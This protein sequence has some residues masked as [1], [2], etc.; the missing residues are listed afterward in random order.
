[1]IE[2]ILLFQAHCSKEVVPFFAL[3]ILVLVLVATAIPTKADDNKKRVKDKQLSGED[4]I[5]NGE[6]NAD[7]DHEAFLGKEERQTF[8]QLSPE[9]SRERLGLII[10]KIDKNKDGFVSEDELK[11]WIQYVQ[12]RYISTDTDRMWKDYDTTEDNKI[13]WDAYMKRT[14][15]YS[16]GRCHDEVL[17][18]KDMISRDKR[19]WERA[20]TDK[21]NQLNKE[22]FSNF[23]H[24]EDAEH[25]REIVVLETLEDIDKDK[26]GFINEDE[27]IGDM[28]PDH[29]IGDPEPDW[30]ASE[31]KQFHDFRD[32]NKD[33]KMDPKEVMDWIIPA[34]YDH[35]A[36]ESK[37]LIYESD[38]DK[39]NRLTKQEILDKHDMFVGS[40]ATDFGEAL[41]R[42]DE[43]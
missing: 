30:V 39:D 21:D 25:M 16:E 14:Y 15:G 5:E 24:P 6:H 31:R 19:R 26:D 41:T 13:T 28:L 40:Q 3:L 1:M 9:E 35:S 33:G 42:H 27:Y 12:K 7:Y 38:V 36:A 20:D 18:Y 23:L 34:D 29:K 37:H 4:H 32:K 2:F 11:D 22:E 8:D 10:D 43:F 17:E